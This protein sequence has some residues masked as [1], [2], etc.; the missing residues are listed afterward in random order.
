MGLIKAGSKDKPA[1]VSQPEGDPL[2]RLENGDAAERRHA[3]HQ[4]ASRPTDLCVR[5][6]RESD[7]SVR[8]V[9]LTALVRGAS[10]DAVFGLLPFLESE[11]AALRNAVIETLQQ[12]PA[13]LVMPYVGALLAHE[14][15]DVRIFTV[16]LV[17]RL[18]HPER[19][20]RL[21]AV[22]DR[23]P[24]VNVCLAAVEGVAE[25]GRPEALPA[26]ERLKTRFPD[27]PVVAFSVDAARRRFAAG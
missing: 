19:M 14:D 20:A 3:A 17:A 21:I 8:E 15:S 23:E 5:L 7:A 10:P 27:D 24:H 26:L 2:D 9:I 13:D 1:E 16:Q 25:A 6:G 12:M 11:D 22:L 4:L 18:P